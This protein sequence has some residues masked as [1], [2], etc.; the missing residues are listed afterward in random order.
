MDGWI[1]VLGSLE[2]YVAVLGS[3][4]DSRCYREKRFSTLPS[5]YL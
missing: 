3:W 5:C 1:E 4:I 2:M